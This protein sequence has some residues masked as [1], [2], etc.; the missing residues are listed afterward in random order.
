MSSSDRSHSAAAGTPRA[1]IGK[2]RWSTSAMGLVA[3]VG[4]VFAA[5]G[6]GGNHTTKSTSSTSTSLAAQQQ[7]A[8]IFQA[9]CASC[10]DTRLAAQVT[11]DFSNIDDEIALVTN[12]RA[13]ALE[14]MPSFAGAL[15]T[16]QI[17][18]VVEYTRVQ[19]GK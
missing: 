5:C 18:D 16:A 17:R 4:L 9:K 11:R 19:L 2:W 13:S 14:T 8:Q 7:G 10:N 1:R 15:T 3:A 6:G 12:G